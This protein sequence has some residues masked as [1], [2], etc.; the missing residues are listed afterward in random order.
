[1]LVSGIHVNADSDVLFL[2]TYSFT[3]KA[4]SIT[5]IRKEFGF[6]RRFICSIFSKWQN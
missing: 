5:K 6:S 3:K 4:F 1:M 2:Y